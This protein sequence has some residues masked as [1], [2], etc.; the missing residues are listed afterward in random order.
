MYRRCAFFLVGL[1]CGAFTLQT[2][3]GEEKPAPQ[4]AASNEKT[5]TPEALAHRIWVITDTVLENH[6]NPPARQAMLLG[7]L[8]ALTIRASKQPLRLA[9]KSSL[10]FNLGKRV[11]E[12]TTEPQWTALFQEIWTA[13]SAAP[14]AIPGAREELVLQGLSGSVPGEANVIDPV[15]MKVMDQ[16]AANRYV[17]TGI[18]IAVNDKEKL[19]QVRIA[20]RHGP[21]YKAGMKTDDLIVAVNGVNTSGMTIRQVVDLIRGEE[22]TP[23]TI[24]VRQ[25]DTQE[26][27]SLKMIRGVVPF[28]TVLGH[29]RTSEDGWNFRVDPAAPIAY[30]QIKSLTSSVVHE[31]RQKE[32]QLQAEGFR[33]L[34]LDMRFNGGGGIHEAAL[35]A[36]ALLDGGLLWRTRDARNKVKEFAADRDCLFRDW[37]VAVL[38]NNREMHAPDAVVAAWQDKHRVIVVGERSTG[39]CFMN[40]RVSLPERQGELMLRTGVLERV[41][42]MPPEG[43]VKP[44]QQVSLTKEELTAVYAWSS[45]QEQ[46]FKAANLNDAA[47]KDPQLAKA[48]EVLKAALAKGSQPGKTSSGSPVLSPGKGDSR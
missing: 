35:L 33:A 8:Q 38:V 19:T 32:A 16:T 27:R 40:S 43:G 47:P 23:V 21:A 13:N 41:G 31:L 24:G 39:E 37:P 3:A 10:P 1:I 22:G 2:L 46:P 44:D 5:V 28:E 36:D 29:Q 48:I 25:P 15:Q 18:Q 45:K 30:L 20:F 12:V 4:V 11:S 26:V 9:N 42:A 34:I 14:T 6:I 17:G 7:S